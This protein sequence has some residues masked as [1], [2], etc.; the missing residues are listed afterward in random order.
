MGQVYYHICVIM[1]GNPVLEFDII[2]VTTVVVWY[3]AKPHNSHAHKDL[4]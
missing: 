1:C 3:S 2:Y 4:R